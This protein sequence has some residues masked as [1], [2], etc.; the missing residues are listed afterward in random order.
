M[1]QLGNQRLVDHDG[2]VDEKVKGITVAVLGDM[3]VYLH[4]G[5]FVLEP[6][7]DLERFEA[8]LSAEL[9]PLL[10]IRVRA[11][12][13]ETESNMA[14]CN[15]ICYPLIDLRRKLP[16]YVFINQCNMSRIGL[17]TY[18]IGSII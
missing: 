6:E 18:I 3:E 5:A 9:L 14:A 16:I 13:E 11:F 10:V 4:L 12:L 2:V 7:L 15:M 1:K 8:E 17:Y